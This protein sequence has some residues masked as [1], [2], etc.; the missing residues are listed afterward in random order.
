[1]SEEL[2][3]KIANGV[4][5]TID[6]IQHL[7]DGSGFAVMSMPLPIDH[8]LTA[9]DGEFEPPPMPMRMGK[10]DPRRRDFAKMLTDAGRYAI[11]AATMKGTDEDFDPD[12][13]IQCLIVGMLG[14]WTDDGLSE[15]AWAN[16]PAER[17]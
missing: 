10:D 11:R 1:M 9:D 15:D 7:P 17:R 12:A 2:V 3:R 5:G 8:W 13:L 14:Y 4:G 16:P 6:E